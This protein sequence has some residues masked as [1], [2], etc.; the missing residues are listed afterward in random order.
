MHSGPLSLPRSRFLI[1]PTDCQGLLTLA[2]TAATSAMISPEHK[3]V[4][5]DRLTGRRIR[6]GFVR[7]LREFR[8]RVLK[9]C[10]DAGSPIACQ[11]APAA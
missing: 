10:P 2:L 6:T 5:P 3:L 11:L 1:S 7:S 8:I 4:K 9:N